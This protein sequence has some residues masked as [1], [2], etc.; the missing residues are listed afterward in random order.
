METPILIKRNDGSVVEPHAAL[1]AIDSASTQL[2]ED[3]YETLI[4]APQWM[5]A[6]IAMRFA[7]RACENA[8]VPPRIAAQV[9]WDAVGRMHDDILDAMRAA[10]RSSHS[11]GSKVTVR[12]PGK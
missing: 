3:D 11:S 1:R 12:H 9:A 2:P 6:E 5:L 4:D 7:T 10:G 8:G